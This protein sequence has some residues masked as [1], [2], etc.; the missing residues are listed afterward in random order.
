MVFWQGTNFGSELGDGEQQ[1]DVG[2]ELG[3]RRPAR[4]RRAHGRQAGAVRSR[5]ADREHPGPGGGALA[6]R[7]DRREDTSFRATDIWA[8]EYCTIYP[9][10]VGVRFVDMPDED[11]QD[12]QFLSRTR[13]DL[14]G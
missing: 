13:H 1:V 11:W 9:D 8:D 3:D 12:T 10:G 4:L 14:P 5:A 2:P 7:V 6:V